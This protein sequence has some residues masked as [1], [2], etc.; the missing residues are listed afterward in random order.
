MFPY[1]VGMLFVDYLYKRGNWAEVNKAYQK[2][3]VSTE[4]ILHPE[5]YIAGETPIAVAPV[6]LADTLDPN[7]KLETTDSLGEFLTYLLMAYGAD[8]SA[9]VTENEAA[10]ASTGW[11][12]DTY[13]VYSRS[14]NGTAILVAHWIW[15]TNRDGSEFETQM[16]KHLQARF[17]G[18]TVSNSQGSCWAVNQQTSCLFT[19]GKHSV[20]IIAPDMKTVTSVFANVDVSS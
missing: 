12:G 9:E 4:Q 5:K 11:G 10:I 13:Q 19:R 20:W 14:D 18:S 16:K 3:P 7:W 6:I 17:R 1:D 2:P 8:Y 15:D